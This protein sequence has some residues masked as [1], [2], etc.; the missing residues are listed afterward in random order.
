M[1][2]AELVQRASHWLHGMGCPIVFAEMVA[3]TRE[4]P[5]AIGWR[6]AARLSYLVEC[7]TSRGD[8]L[9]DR[10]KPH[11]ADGKGMGCYRYF[12]CPPGLIKA[13]E[14]PARW[15]LLYAHAKKVEVVRGR[16]PRKWD[17][18]QQT[19]Y[20]TPD[21]AAEAA[22]LYSALG[23]LRIDLGAALFTE[24]VH[25]PYTERNAQGRRFVIID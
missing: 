8:F 1:T 12:M 22:M 14:L 23:R 19:F 4:Q 15:G 20:H 6:D 5:D 7:K 17:A 16:H 13:D 2:H 21:R 18:S 11:R 10:K 9:A 3:L 24:R 25:K